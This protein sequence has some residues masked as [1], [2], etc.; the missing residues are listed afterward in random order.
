MKKLTLKAIIFA[1]A[2]SCLAGC[3]T[4]KEAEVVEET[5]QEEVAEAL[6][7]SENVTE[8]TAVEEAV[9]EETTYT[10]IDD[11]EREITVDNPQR[12]VTLMG[13]FAE[14]WVLAG[15]ADTLVGTSE[16]TTDTRD[17]GIPETAVNVGSYQDPNMEQLLSVDPDLVLLSAETVRTDNHMALKS[18]LES[19]QIPAAYFGVTHFEDYLRFLK[20]CTDITKNQEAYEKNGLQVEKEIQKI[21]AETTLE[22][23]PSF[24]LLI[25]YSGGVRPQNSDTMTG[26]MLTE[27]GAHNIIDDYPSLLQ[28]FSLEA[29]IEAD[30]DYIFVIAMGNDDEATKRNLEE[31]MESNPV[32]S[33]LSAVKNEQY[34]LLPREQFLYKPNAKWAESYQYLADILVQGK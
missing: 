5:A 32:W 7:K 26:R 25:T 2:V 17:L 13:S 27:L 22:E 10:F 6:E 20:V 23:E 16:D 8:E 24:L 11:L 29:V 4:K 33:S 31:N 28:D 3:G 34:I 30:P 15:G 12:V 21:L 9:Q 18:S 19:M 14:I 1:M